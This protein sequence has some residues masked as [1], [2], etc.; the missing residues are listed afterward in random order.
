M[1]NQTDA[2]KIKA[3]LK[4][5]KSTTQYARIVAVNMVRIKGYT[6]SAAADVLGVDRSTIYDWLNVYD[7]KGLD[8]LADGARPGRPS[9]VPRHTLENIINNT[10]QF[11]AYGFV[12]LAEKK[13][14]IKYSESQARRILRSLGFTIRKT[15]RISDRIPPRKDLEIWQKDTTNEIKILKKDG[16]T[17]IMSDESHQNLSMFGSGAVYTRGDAIPVQTPLGN[18]R[19]TIY[20]GITLDGQTCYMA[21]SKANDRSFIRYLNKTKKRFGKVAVILDNAA[22]HNSNRVKRYLKK[23]NNFVKLIFLPPYSP[24]LNPAEWLWL[25]GKARIRRTFRRPAKRYFRRKIMLIY[26]SLEIKFD[27]RNILFR[28]LDKILPV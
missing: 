7:H 11:T 9:F 23:N 26:E 8:G 6:I 3:A 13:T 1:S 19:Q 18:Q 22:Y 24:F 25:N 17:P 4:Q 14:G 20:G 15:P 27:P 10:K 21:A 2:Q 16:F 12:K 5:T 28:N